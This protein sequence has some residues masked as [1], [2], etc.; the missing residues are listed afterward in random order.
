MSL[1]H[2]LSVLVCAA[3]LM[4]C[5]ANPYHQIEQAYYPNHFRDGKRLPDAEI[6]KLPK[7]K[8]PAELALYREYRVLVEMQRQR[9]IAAWQAV[10]ASAQQFS[11]EM[12]QNT[13]RLVDHN[14]S[15][16]HSFMANQELSRINQNLQ[17][18]DH[19]MT[20]QRIQTMV[21][22]IRTTPYYGPLNSGVRYL[23]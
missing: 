20:M 17:N 9:E 10:A 7:P 18:L 11:A 12:R 21:Q 14:V 4:G 13:Q 6:A 15:S 3:L 23:Y 19:Q 16:M 1:R 5:A 22:P 2:L 8:T